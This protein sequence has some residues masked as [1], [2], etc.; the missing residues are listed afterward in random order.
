MVNRLAS[1]VA[2]MASTRGVY[3]PLFF[4]LCALR[5]YLF[6]CKVL[7]ILI[8]YGLSG[9]ECMGLL[10]LMSSLLMIAFFLLEPLFKMHYVSRWF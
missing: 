9:P 6:L 4:L 8:Y 1:L 2:L 5:C 10:F 7:H 3:Y